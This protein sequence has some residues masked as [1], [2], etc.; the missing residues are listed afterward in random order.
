MQRNIA[1]AYDGHNSACIF[2]AVKTILKAGNRAE[3][4]PADS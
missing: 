3:E 2:S 1:R 4:T